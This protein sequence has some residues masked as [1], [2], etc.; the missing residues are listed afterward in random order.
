MNGQEA[1][2]NSATFSPDGTPLVTGSGDGRSG[3]G[4]PGAASRSAR[5]SS[6]RF[7]ASATFSPDGKGMVSAM[8]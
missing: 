7:G 6:A 3:C 4:T 5:R 2:L 8:E 1:S